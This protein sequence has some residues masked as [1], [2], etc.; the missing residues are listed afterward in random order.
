MAL[1][2]G[3][4]NTLVRSLTVACLITATATACTTAGSGSHEGRSY[5]GTEEAPEFPA[6]LDWINTA[7]PISL[8]ELR[9]KV[10]LLDFWTY[11]C[12]N[13]MHVIPDLER[14]EHE[15]P[16]ELVVIG[17]HSA[18][19]TNEGE[20]EN[21]VDVVQRYG[22]THP[23]VNDNE[24][25]VWNQWGVSA[26]PTIAVIDPA[27]NVVGVRPGEGV[28]DALEPVIASLVAEFDAAGTLD[29]TPR[30]T[31]PDAVTAP[32]QALRYPG[33][34][35]ASNGRLWVADTGHHRVLEVDPSSGD[36]IAA[37]GSGERGFANGTTINATFDTPQGMAVNPQTNEV[38]VADVGNN[39]VRTINL[40]TGAVTTLVGTGELGWPPQGGGLDTAALNSPWDVAYED[41]LVYVANAG[42]HQIWVI[43]VANN[44][45]HPLIGNGAEGTH[46]ARFENAELAQPS[47]LAF[48]DDR[49][50]YFADAESS[51]IRVGDL[52]TAMTSL[53][54][55][56]DSS[57]FEFGDL[58]GVGDVA[59][60]QHPLG[61]AING[62]TLYVADTY[63]SKIKRVDIG[64]GSVSSWLGSERGWADGSSP[65]FNEPG[66]LSFDHGV[67]YVADTNNHSV[68]TIDPATGVTATLILK[69]VEKFDPPTEFVG[70]VITVDPVDASAGPGSVL[71]DYTLPARYKI[72]PDAPSSLVISG[73]H[74]VVSLPSQTAGSLTGASLP[75]VVPLDF[76]EGNGVLTLD[77]NL[78]YCME[79]A[80]SL[81]YIDRARF[82]IPVTVGP[83]GESTQLHVTRTLTE[84]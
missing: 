84:P 40:T 3:A 8:T 64:T 72:N 38:Y 47:G 80:E 41:G 51:S 45:A 11:G 7:A 53:V 9:G 1:T 42:T 16:E 6:E 12:I 35:L 76:D 37:W 77:I 34:V 15:Y 75:A 30:T 55:G 57:L 29:R 39:A 67:L 27:G 28:Y 13:C 78:V 23:V 62:H 54:V 26:W 58:D 66:G 46:N 19:F 2:P 59:R 31:T 33:N 68:R 69:G 49:R 81:C 43:D 73:G 32:R 18:K 22:V 48:S 52:A 61:V 36:V 60:L 21:L 74:N 44:A 20:T 56:G 14:L 63:N 24:F 70:D 25:A 82:V 83:S 79:N 5:A 65:L 10:V 71:I 4:M 50:L 17:V